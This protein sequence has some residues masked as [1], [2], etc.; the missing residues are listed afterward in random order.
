MRTQHGRIQADHSQFLLA[1]PN[2]DTTDISDEGDLIRAEPGFVTIMTGIAYGP[3]DLTVEL[4][5]HAP[6]DTDLGDWQ[7]VEE[8]IARTQSGLCLRFR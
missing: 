8:T 2:V 1:D 5:D 7:V 3:V 6:N 4:L